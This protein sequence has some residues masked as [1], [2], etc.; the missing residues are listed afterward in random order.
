MSKNDKTASEKEP[1]APKN[2]SVYDFLYCDTRRIGSFLAQ[3][4]DAGHLEKIINRD[5]VIKGARRGWKMNVGGGALGGSGSVGLE[6]SPDTHGSESSERVY[7]PLWTNALAFL[8]YL[9]EAGLI[10]RNAADTLIG[11]FL[12][13]KGSLSVIDFT[14]FKGIW[15]M[16]ATKNAIL[17]G[18]NA[19]VQSL[20]QNR[21]Q[22]RRAASKV[23]PPS[24]QPDK[25]VV[26]A[27]LALIGLLPHAIQARLS[28]AGTDQMIWTS[29]RE[30]ALVVSAADLLLKHG[31]SIAGTWNMLGILD[32]RPDGNEDGTTA[33]NEASAATLANSPFL[34]IMKSIFPIIRP[35]LGRPFPAYGMT[36]L[37]I[38]REVSA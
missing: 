24:I 37:M 9:D 10:K 30:D 6:V 7:D 17:S 8:D 22:Q 19:N 14:L 16:Q 34:L 28:V 15:Q 33:D 1:D 2:D 27:G 25:D 20:P 36:P 3:F 18:A 5:A 29:L 11:Q 12:L 4:D 31:T 32:A 26:D 23:A 38:F 13:A 21:Q 35:L